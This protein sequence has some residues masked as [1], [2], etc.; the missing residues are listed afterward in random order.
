[1]GTFYLDGRLGAG[2]QGVV[3]EGYGVDGRRVAVKAL[4]RV[5]DGDRDRLRKEVQA[6][7]R[8]APFCTTEVLHCDLDGSVPF[9]VSEYVAG[10]DLRRAV[11]HDEPYG[12]EELRRPA[13]GVATAL[14][15]I[16]RAGV[17]HRDLKPENILLGPDGPRVIDFGIARIMEGTA[18]AGLPMGTLR[19]MPPERYRGENGDAKVDVWG[20]GRRPPSTPRR[21]GTPSTATAPGR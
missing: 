11:S 15:A 6:W 12:P 9:V 8:V 13:I 21:A 14:V 3:D 20:W 17:V 18:T 1:M 2:G 19:Y 4:H 5:E 10:P 16:H 7:R